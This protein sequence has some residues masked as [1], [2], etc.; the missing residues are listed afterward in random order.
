M[1]RARVVFFL[2]LFL[3]ASL[4]SFAPTLYAQSPAELQAQIEANNTQLTALKAEIA[5]FQAELNSLSTKKDTLQSAISTLSVSQKQLA[6]QIQLTQKQIASANLQIRQLT[7]SIGDKEAAITSDQDAISKAMRVVAAEEGTPLITSL[8]SSDSLGEAWRLTDE[9]TQ[10]NQALADNIRHLRVARTQLATNRD[11][12]TKKKAELVSLQN[13][14]ALQKRSVDIQKAAQQKLLVDTKNQ[15]STYQ[16]IV[17]AKKAEEAAFE[18]AVFELESKLQYAFDPSRVPPA[19]KGILRWP[20]TS[21]SITQQF[22]KTSSSKRLYVSG[23]HNGVDFRALI[24]TPVRTSLTGTVVA[25]NY[26]AVASCQYGK[27][28]LIKHSN[29]LTT[30]YAHLSDISVQK[31]SAV[32]TGQ[33]IGFSGDTGYATGPHLHLSLY[34]SDAV[35]FKQYRCKSGAVVTIPVAPPAA[36]LD[37]LAYL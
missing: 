33:A 6:S 9:M 11:A 15:E 7:N 32:F 8:I 35:S 31:G 16:K 20:L 17:A 29:G 13:D 30:L 26:G 18:A 14:L 4:F 27:W 28:V 3:G 36:Y 25:V 1:N 21:V 22:G 2:L 5:A 23:T 24:G 10:F 37:P 12:V 34:V 19:G